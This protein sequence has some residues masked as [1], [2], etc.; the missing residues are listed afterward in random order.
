MAFNGAKVKTIQSRK[1]C[2]YT[3]GG[4]A[5]YNMREVSMN[6]KNSGFVKALTV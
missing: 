4:I 1:I 3:N 2:L 5:L 6:F